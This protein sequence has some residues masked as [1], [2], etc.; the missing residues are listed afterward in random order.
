MSGD[1]IARAIYLG[2][3]LLFL[4]GVFGLGGR[5]SLRGLRDMLLWAMIFLMA[6]LAYSQRETLRD[7]LFPATTRFE[8]G[9]IELRRQA[10]G[11]F[12]AALK[13]NGAPVTFMIDTGA[14][15]IVLSR[16]DAEAAGI[17]VAGL[18]YLARAQTAN[19]LARLAPVRLRRISLG[20]TGVSNVKANVSAGGLGISLLG[21]D[22]LDRFSKIEIEGDRMRLVP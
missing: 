16:P 13:V 1:E 15:R 19:G 8:G 5:A 3:L 6:I 14:T 12:Y 17:D 2:L 9:A 20:E 18:D 21:M 4:L 22:F 11:H 7:N 10:D